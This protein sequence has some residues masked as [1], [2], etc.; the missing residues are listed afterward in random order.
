[1]LV[2][3][4]SQLPHLHYH[5]VSPCVRAARDASFARLTSISML[6]H[7]VGS[8]GWNA[9]GAVLTDKALTTRYAPPGSYAS[10]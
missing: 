4:V 8:G 7:V 2:H 9:R 10:C 6:L 5:P 3:P 1:M